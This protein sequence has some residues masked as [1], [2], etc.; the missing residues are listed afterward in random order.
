VDI[1]ETKASFEMACTCALD[2]R[3]E[4]RSEVYLFCREARVAS[5]FLELLYDRTRDA[6]I[7]TV[8]Y[9]GKLAL[10]TT[11]DDVLVT[12]K[13]S[14]LKEE[15]TV[16]CQIAGVSRYGRHSSADP[17][18]AVRAD[19]GTDSLGQMQDNNAHLFPELT[20]RPGIFV[21]GACRGQYYLP[22][23]IR[24][25][26]AAAL[27]VYSLLS[28]KFMT[29]ELSNAVVDATKCALCLTCIRSCPHRAMSVDEE[30]RAAMSMPEVCQKCGVCVGE[31]PA[32][33]IELPVA[34]G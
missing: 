1:E 16:A 34:G 18:L 13:D 5:E 19:I 9:E 26:K 8:K 30:K 33:A 4:F 20:N 10:E 17:S 6:G 28:R 22:D 7:N 3:R 15:V 24:D 31:C 32:A 14:S 11:E 23:V 29:V 27:G 21:V 12:V 25:A 2:L